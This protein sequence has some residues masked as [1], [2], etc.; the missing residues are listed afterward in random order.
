MVV[1]TCIQIVTAQEKSRLKKISLVY[2]DHSPPDTSGAIFFKK[3]YLPKIQK[4]LAG[5]GYELDVTFHH[6]ESLY[7]YNDQVNVCEAGIIDITLFSL[8][9]EIN[10]APLHEVIVMPLL[11]FNEFS[12]TRVWFELQE[13]IPE[14]G[15]ELSPFKELFHFNALP[16]VFNMKIEARVPK[17]Y[18]GLKIQC[19][20]MVGEMF[21]SIGA[22]PIQQSP[23]DWK[24]SLKNNLID[25]I[26]TGITGI[27]LFDLQD[28]VKVHIMPSE[29]SFGLQG[30]SIIMNREKFE[31]FPPEVQKVLNDNV[32]WASMRMTEIEANNIPKN[33]KICKDR[34]NKFIYLTK[35]EM[36]EWYKVFIPL[37][38]KWIKKIE[39][40]GLPGQKVYDEAKR[41]AIKYR[42]QK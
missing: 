4:E 6:A 32:M 29:D 1:F 18:K 28:A 14:F 9:Y 35:K 34:G 31:S 2:S 39:S 36:D 21:Q 20:T 5:V 33:I 17:D 19:P 37:H 13:T 42:N 3:E 11:G 30:A 7:K 38:E 40:M 10:R 15:S 41:L 22:F 25:G 23:I 8:D 27:P 26:V 12:A 16:R 24:E